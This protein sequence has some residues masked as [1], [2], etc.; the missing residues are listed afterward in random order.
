MVTVNSGIINLKDKDRQCF[1]FC[2]DLSNKEFLGVDLDD[3]INIKWSLFRLRQ[4][5]DIPG[6]G[7]DLPNSDIKVPGNYYIEK[8]KTDDW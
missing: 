6:G 4:A 5:P 8:I 1:S 3:Q 7:M 2:Q